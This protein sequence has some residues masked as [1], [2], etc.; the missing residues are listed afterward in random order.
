MSVLWRL[1]DPS[2]FQCGVKPRPN[3]RGES[4]DDTTLEATKT[5]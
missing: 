4:G 5:R 3:S 1:F 2:H